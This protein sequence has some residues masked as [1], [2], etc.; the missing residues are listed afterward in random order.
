VLKKI[1]RNSKHLSYEEQFLIIKAII[2]EY[3]KI[4]FSAIS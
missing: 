2:P 3:Y 1:G 4:I